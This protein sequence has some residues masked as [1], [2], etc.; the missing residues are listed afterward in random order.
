MVIGG[1]A[2]G[3]AALTKDQPQ[4]VTATGRDLTTSAGAAAEDKVGTGATPPAATGRIE[5]VPPLAAIGRREA[6]D[7]ADRTATRSPRRPAPADT[8][9]A[10]PTPAAVAPTAPVAAT[11][12]SVVRTTVTETRAIP[13]G[14]RLVSDPT[15]PRGAKRVQT[16]GVPGEET[17]RY[18]VTYVG[19][20]EKE[21]QLLGRSVAREPQERVIAFGSQGRG[22][23][24]PDGH[25]RPGGP[26]RHRG[27][28]MSLGG[29]L[30]IGRSA[31]PEEES[32]SIDVLDQDL[33]M[34][35]PDALD[36]LALDPNV[37]C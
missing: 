19:G 18:L 9:A 29:C 5:A 30:P 15:M 23:G 26:G 14:T 16:E 8:A 21:R 13:F 31:C 2:A 27:C 28:G 25:G 7:E 37:T 10:A 3:V 22:P 33:S 6:D 36:G 12:P 11:S 4:M 32:G 34:I 35:D 1:G 24:G 17:L 20:Q